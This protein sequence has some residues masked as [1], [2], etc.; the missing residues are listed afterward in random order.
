M[1][2]ADLLTPPGR[3]LQLVTVV[4]EAEL[5]GRWGKGY[6]LSSGDWGRQLEPALS[7]LPPGREVD[8]APAF[9]SGP[10]AGALVEEL[11]RRRATLVAIGGRDYRRLPG[12]LLGSVAVALLHD[13]PCS[14]FVARH[15]EGG[16]RSFRSVAVGYDGSPLAAAALATAA[17]IARRLDARASVVVAEGAEPPQ[18]PGIAVV[19]DPRP[20]VEALRDAACDLLVLGSRGLH[21]VRALGSVSERVAGTSAASVLVVRDG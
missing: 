19:E 7:A 10:P 18:A 13:A 17:A 8:A 16:P 15:D 1:R 12:V 20:P 3:T 2:Q 4:G 5:G 21:G 9:R 11:K 6:E 14:V